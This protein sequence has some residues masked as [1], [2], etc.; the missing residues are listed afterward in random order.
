LRRYHSEPVTHLDED[1]ETL[2]DIPSRF[3]KVAKVKKREP[4]Q[5]KVLSVVERGARTRKRA[6][7][8]A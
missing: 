8:A 2:I 1:V 6:R 4:G 7:R 3:M 5:V